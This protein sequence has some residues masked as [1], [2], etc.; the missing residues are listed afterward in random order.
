VLTAERSQLIGV[1][2]ATVALVGIF[3]VSGISMYS[4]TS[5]M[6]DRFL[7]WGYPVWFRLMVGTSEILGAVLLAIPR[8]AFY[9]ASLLGIV[10]AGA[11]FTH[12]RHGEWLP[13]LF[14]VIVLFLLTLVGAYR[15]GRP[16]ARPAGGV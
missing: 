1:L 14:V 15:R 3:L 9:G 13:T 16:P 8:S 4:D 6:A 10:M 5:P 2:F 12:I 11:L 7:F